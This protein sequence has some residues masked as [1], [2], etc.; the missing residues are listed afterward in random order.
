MTRRV[1]L[2]A[3]AAG[4]ICAGMASEAQAAPATQLVLSQAAAFSLLGHSCGGIQERVYATGFGAN[5]YPTGDVYMQTRC[6]GSGRGGGY[7]STTYSGWASVVWTWLGETRSSTQLQGAAE[8]DTAFSATD[9]YGDRVYNAGSAAYL[10]VGEPPLQPPAA[11]AGVSAGVGPFEAGETEYLRMTVSWT[12]AGETA[13]LITSSTVT[14]TPVNSSAP[15]LTA[16][17]SGSWSTAYLSPVQPNTTYRVSVTNTDSEGTSPPSAPLELTSPNQDG[18]GEREQKS[19]Q[20]CESSHGTIRLSPGLSETPQVQSITVKGEFSECDGPLGFESAKF[21]DRL[22]TT[23]EVTCSA[24][25]SASAE[26]TTQQVSLSVKWLPHE[27]G[28]STGSLSLPVSEVAASGLTGTLEHG[29][30][31][32]PA[33]VHTAWVAES[34]AG[35]AGCGQA[36]GKKAAKPVKAGAFS[37][38]EVE[39]G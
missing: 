39:F 13:G 6:G 5:G 14:A 29:P 9:A 8:E 27:V 24:L 17:A 37:T 12:A 36:S 30:F 32:A 15:V 4:A 2:G 26:P 1:W 19:V 22:T 20:T 7:K 33:A 10:E 3:I 25:A 23:D 35:A 34:F 11:P 16:T 21:V 28:S 31:S 18:E 38:G